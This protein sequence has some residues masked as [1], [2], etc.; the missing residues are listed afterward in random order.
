MIGSWVHS[1]NLECASI[2]LMEVVPEH[3]RFG[4]SQGRGLTFRNPRL[5]ISL[6]FYYLKINSVDVLN[7]IEP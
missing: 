2:A 4:V 3:T 5:R 6:L 1:R 7:D